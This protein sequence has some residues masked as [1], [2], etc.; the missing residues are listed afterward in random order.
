MLMLLI[1]TA[2]AVIFSMI[3]TVVDLHSD[4]LRRLPERTFGPSRND[5]LDQLGRPFTAGLR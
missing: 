3:A 1:L 2:A 4:G 5:D